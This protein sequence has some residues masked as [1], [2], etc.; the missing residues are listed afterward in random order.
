MILKLA[1]KTGLNGNPT[2]MPSSD[3]PPSGL[4]RR[5]DNSKGL[6]LIEVIV[7]TSISI[8]VI[9]FIYYMYWSGNE[10]WEIKS[11]QTDLQAQGR[12][13][14]AEMVKELRQATRT[15]TQNP[16][17]DL[18]IPSQ[19]NNKDAAFY[20]PTDADGDGLITDSNG[21]IEWDTSNRIEYQYVPGL[22]LLRRLEKGEQRTLSLDV[23]DVQFIDAGIDNQLYPNEVRIVLTLS[24]LTPRQRTV[25]LTF[26]AIVRLR[27]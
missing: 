11:Y 3:I 23:T 5:R 9:T 2:G 24:R 12:R 16:S 1:K 22:K 14:M 21:A 19:P 26:T 18:V 20:L 4:L 17:P 8:I 6:T 7:A 13:V 10:L 27:N 15:S 25:T